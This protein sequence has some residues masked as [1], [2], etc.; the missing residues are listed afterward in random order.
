VPEAVPI[1]LGLLLGGAL[2]FFVGSE[3]RRTYKEN[4]RGGEP[5]PEGEEGAPEGGYYPSLAQI[6]SAAE[7]ARDRV[8]DEG[9]PERPCIVHQLDVTIVV[10]DKRAKERGAEDAGEEGPSVHLSRGRE[11]DAA[12]V[13]ETLDQLLAWGIRIRDQSAALMNHTSRMPDDA[14]QQTSALYDTAWVFAPEYLK[15]LHPRTDEGK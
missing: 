10:Q 7:E 6:R 2:G 9:W 1:I 14:S 12:L 4:R 3:T 8:Q 5:A 15:K 13:K 11:V